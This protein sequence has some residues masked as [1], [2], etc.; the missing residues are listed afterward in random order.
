M[1]LFLLGSLSPFCCK[2]KLS[3]RV[4]R[5][6]HWFVYWSCQRHA[7]FSYISKMESFYIC[8]DS[9][10]PIFRSWHKPPGLQNIFRVPINILFLIILCLLYFEISIVISW[11]LDHYNPSS[12]VKIRVRI[13]LSVEQLMLIDKTYLGVDYQAGMFE[14]REH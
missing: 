12:I 3:Y 6:Q 13:W 2:Y 11:Y 9:F 5:M 10:R 1:K 14:V 8:F 7:A 4:S